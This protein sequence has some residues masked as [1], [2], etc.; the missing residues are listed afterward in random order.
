M[1]ERVK[2]GRA[3]EEG[4]KRLRWKVIYGGE[5]EEIPPGAADV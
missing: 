1:K 5:V 2:G 3:G 4:L